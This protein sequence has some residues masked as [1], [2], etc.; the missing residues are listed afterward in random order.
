MPTL[1]EEDPLVSAEWLAKH[2]DAPDIRIVDGTW[3]MPGGPRDA[4]LMHT[5]ARIPGAV[6]FDIDDVSDTDSPLPHMLPSPEKFSSRI[7]KLGIGDGN[8]IVIYDASGIFSAPRIWW[9][10][11]VMGVEDVVVLDGGLPAW[12]IAGL[13]LEDG[14]PITPFARHFTARLHQ[15]LLIDADGMRARV[16]QG[17]A[18]IIDARSS[19]RFRG[20]EPEP[21]P[22]VPSGHMPGAAN[23]PWQN[24]L[25]PDHTMK[26]ALQ[27]RLLFEGVGIDLRKPV[28]A[29]CGS[30]VSACT[31]A[32]ALARI[33]IWDAQVYDGSWCEWTSLPDAPIA[34]EDA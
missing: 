4:P 5:Q 19:G 30:G 33:G 3:F 2:L 6:F 18:G 16:S 14:P 24:V 32:L 25:N 7:H 10:F 8:R 29:T 27:L 13:P 26:S 22:G 12:K 31:L 17:G 28:V 21:R 23:V 20:T 15:E 9:M 34:R 11:R 1:P